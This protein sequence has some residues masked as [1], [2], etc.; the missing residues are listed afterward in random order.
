M[1]SLLPQDTLAFTAWLSLAGSPHSLP[2]DSSST[3]P[4]PRSRNTAPR[5]NSSA[6]ARE[7]ATGSSSTRSAPDATAIWARVSLPSTA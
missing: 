6:G 2:K 4:S 7:Y 1:A 5:A 3:Q